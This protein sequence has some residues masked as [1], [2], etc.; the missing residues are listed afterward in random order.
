[1]KKLF[2]TFFIFALWRH[3]YLCATPQLPRVRI[4]YSSISSIFAGL[5]VPEV[6]PAGFQT[7]LAW[8]NK[9]DIAP[10]RFYDDMITDRLV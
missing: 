3:V 1:M 8:E 9:S 5:R 10:S 4:A 2:L 7:V 6:D